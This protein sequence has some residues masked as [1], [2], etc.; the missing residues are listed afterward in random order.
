MFWLCHCKLPIK[1][2]KLNF[3]KHVFLLGPWRISLLPWVWKIKKVVWKKSGI[4][5]EFCPQKSVR[6]LIKPWT[7]EK[8]SRML[9]VSRPIRCEMKPQKIRAKPQ[10]WL[11]TTRREKTSW[12]FSTRNLR[13]SN[14]FSNNEISLS[15]FR[16]LYPQRIDMTGILRKIDVYKSRS[17]DQTRLDRMSESE[18][19]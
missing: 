17:I 6:T 9:I 2:L 13:F 1:Q 16:H 5:L 12:L 11:V 18:K 14:I 7:P 4:S 19:N 10:H 15:R 8:I 3:F